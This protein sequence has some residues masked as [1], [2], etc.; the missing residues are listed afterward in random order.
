MG[1]EHYKIAR[2]VQEVLQRYNELQDI[3]AILGLD[4]LDDDDKQVVTRARRIQRFLSQPIHVAERFTGLK[5]IYVP[6][7]ETLRGFKA[8]IDGE[9]DSTPRPHS[10][11]WEPLTK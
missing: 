4:E 6:L 11:T 10:L 8:I 1:E 3:I 7:S 5:G 2:K 9:M